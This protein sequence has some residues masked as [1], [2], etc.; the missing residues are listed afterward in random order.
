MNVANCPYSLDVVLTPSVSCCCCCCVVC[1]SV[2]LSHHCE[3]SAW[4]ITFPEAGALSAAVVYSTF[5][6]QIDRLFE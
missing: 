5:N 3:R 6:Q 1:L 4:Q 2:R